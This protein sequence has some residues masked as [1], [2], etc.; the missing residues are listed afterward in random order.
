VGTAIRAIAP[1]FI[2]S[3]FATGINLGFA[4]GHLAWI[5][6][7][8]FALLL[9]VAVYFLPEAAEGRPEKR[10]PTPTVERGEP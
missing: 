10:S 9:N 6:L 4:D 5:V 8:A 7:I 2:T 1:A 3:I